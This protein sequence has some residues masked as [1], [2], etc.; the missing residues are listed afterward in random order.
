ME[1]IIG[2]SKGLHITIW[3][4]K[5]FEWEPCEL[6]EEGTH[7]DILKLWKFNDEKYKVLLQIARDVMTV[8]VSTVAF[9]YAF[10]T[11]GRVLDY[12]RSSLCPK[13]EEALIC[14]PIWLKVIYSDLIM[15]NQEEDGDYATVLDDIDIYDEIDKGIVTIVLLNCM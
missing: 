5:I 13:L 8:Q 4:W 7:W 14:G 15:I 2:C 9:E 10:S 12:F 3:G 6:L 11:G 1:T